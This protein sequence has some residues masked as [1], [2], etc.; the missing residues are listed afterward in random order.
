MR[1]D[2]QRFSEAMLASASALEFA[3][4]TYSNGKVERVDLGRMPVRAGEDLARV[5]PWLRGRN[6]AGAAIWARPA[7]AA[8]SWIFL[9][10]L[11]VKRARGIAEKYRAIVVETSPGNAQVWICAKRDLGREQRQVV[12]RALAALIG[13]DPHAI[14]EPRWGRLPGFK[15]GKEGRSWT[16]LVVVSHECP[17]FEPAPYFPPPLPTTVS[18]RS[19]VI[20]G[21]VSSSSSRAKCSES[22]DESAREFAY[23]CHALSAG[24]PLDHVI[25]RVTAHAAARGKRGTLEACRAYAQRTVQ[26]AQQA[27]F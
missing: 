1:D 17:F 5:L 3:A 27:V 23:A 21:R 11:P 4:A 24:T 12:N 18:S 14:A 10:D 7:D 15:S 2:P 22:V 20:G 8:H 9:D 6:A 16:N 13:A 19:A 26:R 25:E